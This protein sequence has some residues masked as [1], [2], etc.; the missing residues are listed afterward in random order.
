MDGA[1]S[2]FDYFKSYFALKSLTISAETS[3]ISQRWSSDHLES[4]SGTVR[5]GGG[6]E[7][8]RITLQA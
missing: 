3:L 6:G 2:I 5:S 8:G 4:W 1:R 7:L